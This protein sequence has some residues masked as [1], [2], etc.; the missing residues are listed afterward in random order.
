MKLVK[1][2]PGQIAKVG[3]LAIRNVGEQKAYLRISAPGDTRIRIG[4]VDTPPPGSVESR[5]TTKSG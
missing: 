5:L 1:L 2:K 4:K 3:D